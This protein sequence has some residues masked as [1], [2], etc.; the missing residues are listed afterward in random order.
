MGQRPREEIQ[1]LTYQAMACYGKSK[2]HRTWH[3]VIWFISVFF[4]FGF[5]VGKG[6]S[7]IGC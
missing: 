4:F 2:G 7:W 6:V 3:A 5:H 1:P